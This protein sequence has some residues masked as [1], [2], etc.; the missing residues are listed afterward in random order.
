MIDTFYVLDFKTSG[1]NHFPDTIPIEVAIFRMKWIPEDKE[2]IYDCLLDEFFDWS[3]L[4]KEEINGSWWSQNTG[5]DFG[6]VKA[7]ANMPIIELWQKI[8]DILDAGNVCSWNTKFDFGNILIQMMKEYTPF[9]FNILQCPM[10]ILTNTLQLRGYGPG[11]KYPT[12]SEAIEFYNI[13][14][15]G[16][17]ETIMHRAYW[18]VSYVCKVLN[19]AI[20]RLHYFPR[21]DIRV[22]NKT[23]PNIQRYTSMAFEDPHSFEID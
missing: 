18:D 16:A 21:V 9:E 10:K 19:E 17:E 3:A 23:R 4:Y 13:K 5:L 20:S 12:L 8:S 22:T 15:Y 1:L 11:Y 7:N 2:F 6:Y 14:F